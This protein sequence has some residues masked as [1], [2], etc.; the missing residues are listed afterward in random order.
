MKFF[1]VVFQISTRCVKI[2]L[3][4]TYKIFKKINRAA[5]ER[6]DKARE[7]GDALMT[8]LSLVGESRFGRGLISHLLLTGDENTK[9]RC[10]VAL[11]YIIRY[12]L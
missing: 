8:N 10:A 4:S 11:A 7:L 1:H 6:L 12:L 3:D 2:K 5:K 9:V